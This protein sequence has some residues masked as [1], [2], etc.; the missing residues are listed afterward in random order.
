MASAQPMVGG[1]GLSQ[2]K[3]NNTASRLAVA[4]VLGDEWRSRTPDGRPRA[5]AAPGEQQQQQRR[6][7]TVVDSAIPA[8]PEVDEPDH[9]RAVGRVEAAFTV[10]LQPA[11]AVV[12]LGPFQYKVT[13][14]DVI[15]HPK[16]VGAEVNDVIALEKVLLLG[17]PQD[18]TIGRPYVPGACVVAAVESHFRETKVHVFK[19]KVRKRYSKLQGHRSQMTALRILQVMP[20]G[21]PADWRQGAAP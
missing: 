11:F 17:T 10:P 1:G 21:L 20:E 13:A 4:E 15:L 9:W 8:I 16:L 2:R 5:G 19:K 3:E 18:T 7:P 6:P 14:D 12:Q